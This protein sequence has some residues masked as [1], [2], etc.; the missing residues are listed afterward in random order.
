MGKGSGGAGKLAVKRAVAEAAAALGAARAEALA[1]G[2]AI[3]VS[4]IAS[5]VATGIAGRV[6]V[7]TQHW[8]FNNLDDGVRILDWWPGTGRWRNPRTGAWGFAGL[9]SEVVYLCAMVKRE[10]RR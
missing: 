3:R 1:L 2:I 4:E 10:G 5:R 7:G 8:Q 6:R 9:A